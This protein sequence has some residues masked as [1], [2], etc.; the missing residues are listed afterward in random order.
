MDE[1]SPS[2]RITSPA[3]C[4]AVYA[5]TPATQRTRQH[6]PAGVEGGGGGGGR[7]RGWREPAGV[8]GLAGT[9]GNGKPRLGALRRGDGGIILG[10]G[11]SGPI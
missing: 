8:E 10:T 9:D 1:S 5:D 11:G 6:S 4:C 3:E 2:D 7:R